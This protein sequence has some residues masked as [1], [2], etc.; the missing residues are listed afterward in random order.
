[1]FC[2][3]SFSEVEPS[4]EHALPKWL[5]KHHPNAEPHPTVHWFDG[6]K[7]RYGFVDEGRRAPEKPFGHEARVVCKPCNEGWMNDLE[8][9]VEP[10]LVPL[11]LGEGRLLREA[12]LRALAFW[13]FK[14]ASMLACLGPKYAHLPADHYRWAYRRRRPPE[15]A[16]A[17][18]VNVI[19]SS[20]T[21]E[22]AKYV[23][24]VGEGDPATL[25]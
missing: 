16:Q 17:W 4:K 20:R 24:S 15:T 11:M 19:E 9:A 25:A 1:V 7:E 21:A 14:T 22:W 18:M 12:E 5:G 23:A 10:I 3:R 13:T 8:G 6:S 2:G